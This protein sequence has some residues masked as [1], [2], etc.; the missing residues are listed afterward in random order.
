[1][2]MFEAATND[3]YYEMGLK[4]AQIVREALEAWRNR[5]SKENVHIG[6]KMEQESGPKSSPISDDKNSQQIEAEGHSLHT[7]L[8]A[9][10]GD[11]IPFEDNNPNSDD[12]QGQGRPR[13]AEDL[14]L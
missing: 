3:G 13:D 1:M 4:V 12:I 14:L 5:Q 8:L 2:G 10:E 9:D 7:S 11:S 6:R